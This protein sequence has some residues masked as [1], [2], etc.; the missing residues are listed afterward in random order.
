[1]GD[2]FTLDP[3]RCEQLTVAL[4]TEVSAFYRAQGGV[5]QQYVYEVLNALAVATAFVIAG[6]APDGVLEC[7][8]FF[9]DAISGQLNS[10]LAAMREGRLKPEGLH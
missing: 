6:T 3:E 10:T 5:K 4:S 9:S 7:L 2:E 8:E 1:M